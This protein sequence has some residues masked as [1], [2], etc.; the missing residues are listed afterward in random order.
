M[1]IRDQNIERMSE[2]NIENIKTGYNSNLL[3]FLCAA[4]TYNAT[5]G[6]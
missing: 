4:F 6:G 3:T 5:N 1:L 2:C